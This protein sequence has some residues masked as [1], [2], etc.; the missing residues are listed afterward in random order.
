MYPCFGCISLRLPCLDF[1]FEDRALADPPV[2]ALAAQHTDLNLHH[3][4]PGG[5]FGRVMKFQVLDDAMR[6]GCWECLI[7][8]AGGVA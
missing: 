3:V 5:I 2:E 7:Q 6:F 1:R 8:S 4:Q